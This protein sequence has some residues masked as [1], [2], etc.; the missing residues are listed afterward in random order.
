MASSISGVAFP[1]VATI[2]RTFLVW[3]M[4]QQ[5]K[6]FQ[7]DCLVVRNPFTECRV[8]MDDVQPDLHPGVIMRCSVVLGH[9]LTATKLDELLG[10]LDHLVVPNSTGDE[11]LIQLKAQAELVAPD[12]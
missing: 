1:L 12:F 9:H 6:N 10:R 5:F 7:R 2:Q 3:I 8:S 11:M 4:H